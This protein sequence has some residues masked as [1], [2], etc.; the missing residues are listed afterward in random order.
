MAPF[1]IHEK[2]K[3]KSE[4]TKLRIQIAQGTNESKINESSNNQRSLAKQIGTAKKRA[5]R[6]K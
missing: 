3:T 5:K 4:K 6:L 1:S 2:K